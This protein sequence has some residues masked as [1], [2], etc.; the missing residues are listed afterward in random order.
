MKEFSKHVQDA[1]EMFLKR[2]GYD[3]LDANWECPDGDGTVDIIAEDEGSIAFVQLKGRDGRVEGFGFDEATML[4]PL[5]GIND[6]R[7][8]R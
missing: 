5:G 4:R 3:I 8:S 2:R 6:L 1:A 7:S